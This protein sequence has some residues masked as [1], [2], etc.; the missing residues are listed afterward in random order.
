[1][2]HGIALS[3]DKVQGLKNS[4]VV[5][6]SATIVSAVPLTHFSRRDDL[7]FVVLCFAMPKDED[8]FCERFGW[9]CLAEK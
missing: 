4:D 1:M 9:E 2:P 8:A 3:A 5:H 7:A 6:S